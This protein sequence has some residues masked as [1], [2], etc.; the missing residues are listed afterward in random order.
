MSQFVD[1]S[2]EDSARSIRWNL[3]DVL[4]GN[5]GKLFQTTVLDQLESMLV[6]FERNRNSLTDSISGDVFRNMLERYEKISRLNSRLGS[7]SYMYFSED[8]KSQE[9]KGFKAR[10]EE[11]NAD[12][13]NR[14]LFFELWW[15]SLPTKKSD[16]L[17]PASRKYSYFLR[18]LIQTKP[19]TL[20]E[21]VEQA[22]NLKDITGR[23]AL[24]Q[25][26]HQIRDSFTYDVVLKT[27]TRTLMEEKVRDLFHSER[28]DERR[29]AYRGML[30]KFEQNRDVLGEIYKMIVR[31]WRNEGIKLRG[32]SS[33]ISI[34]NIGNDV[35]D[36][37][38]V[39][40][41]KVCK[42]N[43]SLF[44]R[45]FRLKAKM[46]RLSDFSRTDVYAP[47]RLES[48]KK[49]HWQEGV[50]LV[51]ETFNSFDQKFASMA[52]NLI[53]QSHVDAEPREGK[54]GG[55]YCMSITPGIT[56]YVLLSY[57]G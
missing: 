30:S 41:L 21:S 20:S 31:D 26:Y 17:I 36:E 27:G 13:A 57:T 11:I 34:R 16:E 24:L 2:A 44:Q 8:T 4:P 10:A 3:N 32:Y 15:K 12:S 37:A 14:T 55:A 40:L 39:G 46:L 7:Y 6:E 52:S 22:I 29:A 42:T 23:K 33:P 1:G 43:A 38:V 50:K 28:R 49:Y 25:I 48:E 54:L 5:S 51:L 18:R 53:Y 9:A 35:P 47:I 19:Y 56:P 45:F